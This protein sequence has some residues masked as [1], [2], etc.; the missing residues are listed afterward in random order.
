MAKKLILTPGNVEMV[1]AILESFGY[2]STLRFVNRV[3][4]GTIDQ[5]QDMSLRVSYSKSNGMYLHLSGKWMTDSASIE[6]YARELKTA[7]RMFSML[8]ANMEVE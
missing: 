4:F 1:N 7:S 5:Q 6:Q 2:T 8:E 3:Q